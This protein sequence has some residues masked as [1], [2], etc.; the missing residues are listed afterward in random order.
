MKIKK[1]MSVMLSLLCSA[2]LTLPS[3]A[4]PAT[5]EGNVI[6]EETTES[7]SVLSESSTYIYTTDVQT[8]TSDFE[9]TY[10][11][12][13]NPG[14]IVPTTT[15]AVIEEL[16]FPF[17]KPVE[18]MIYFKNTDKGKWMKNV[19]LD[20]KI[21]RRIYDEKG[22]TIDC[23]VTTEKLNTGDEGFVLYK[24]NCEMLSKYVEYSFIATPE[25]PEGFRITYQHSVIYIN[26]VEI[27]RNSNVLS[28]VMEFNLT[29]K[30]DP[31][32]NTG[33]P[34]GTG[35]YGTTTTTTTATTAYTTTTTMPIDKNY[36]A[37]DANCDGSVSLADSVLV[38]QAFSNPDV[39]G[40]DGKSEN[41]IT[42]LGMAN[43]DV[44]EVGTG[45]TPQDA[46]SIQKYLLKL[47]SEL[48][49]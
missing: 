37:G 44:Y 30:E 16:D 24:V 13:P 38:L 29:E 25:I 19:S 8:T 45:L 49:E 5:A 41:H 17:A 28:K 3:L 23:I 14:M 26:G 42:E 34:F 46:L 12:T 20:L 43:A 22:D 47:V 36:K 15:T 31:F 4:V 6:I 9:T 39:Y 48:P 18:L 7:E 2:T 10:T 1:I 32:A 33:D 35:I 21:T 11:T 40:V 27:E